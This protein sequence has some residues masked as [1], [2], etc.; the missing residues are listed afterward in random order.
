MVILIRFLLFLSILF[1]AY[2][3]IRYL[4]NPRRKFELARDQQQLYIL[5]DFNDVRKNMFI[6]HRGAT[7]EAEKYMGS[8]DHAF[9]VVRIKV[10]PQQKDD[11]HGMSVMDFEDIEREIIKI[12]PYATIEWTHPIKELL[13]R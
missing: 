5:D 12:Y 9:R 4:Y 13:K 6:T 3:F 2:L 10:W 8:T 7:F 1:L 11:L